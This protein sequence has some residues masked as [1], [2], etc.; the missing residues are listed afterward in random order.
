LYTPAFFTRIGLRYRDVIRRSSLNLQ[1][2]AW[3]ELLQDRVSGVLSS[4]QV[5]DDVERSAQQF[6]IRLPGDRGRLLA[7]HGTVFDD[8]SKELCYVIDADFFHDKQMEPSDAQEC[9]DFLHHQARL[10]F[11]WCIKDRLHEAMRPQPLPGA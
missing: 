9:L 2:V 5:S 6:Q 3:S 7:N 10:F 4:P 8:V 11:R 1:D